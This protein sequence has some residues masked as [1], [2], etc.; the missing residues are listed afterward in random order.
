MHSTVTNERL[1]WL[2]LLL[3]TAALLCA[4]CEVGSS[5]YPQPGSNPVA[6][7][8]CPPASVCFNVVPGA[9]GPLGATRIVLFWTPPNESKPP[10]IA[11]LATLS[12]SERS[13][14][15]SRAGIPLPRSTIDMG[16]AWGYVFAVPAA[17]STTPSPKSA[18]GIAQMMF[19]HAV[20]ARWQAPLMG[21]KFPAGMPEGTA[22]YR[23]QRGR[24]FDNF[25]LAENGAVFDLVICPTTES[26]CRLSYPNPK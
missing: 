18:V 10:E 3:T 19:V 2:H 15:L 1:R 20:N 24:M 7:G 22:A 6:P 8:T 16:Q 5:R 4:G 14:V 12:G 17:E 25:V 26:Q 21:D 9:A 23:M 13:L 11:T